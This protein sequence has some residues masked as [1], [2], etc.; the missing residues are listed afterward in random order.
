MI[1]LFIPQTL[2]P[3][4]DLEPSTQQIHYLLHVMRVTEGQ[5]ILVFNG[6]DGEWKV[7]IYNIGKRSCKLK[8]IEQT[9]KQTFE[10]EL[11][12]IFSPLKPKPQEFLIEKATEIGA[13]HLYPVTTERSSTPRFNVEKATQQA[14]EAAEQS[15]R[16]TIPKIFS[17]QPLHSV[18]RNVSS[19][20]PLLVGDET[21]N[22]EPLILSKYNHAR[23]FIIGPEGGWTPKELEYFRSSPNIHTVDLMSNILRAETAGIVGLATLQQMRKYK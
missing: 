23:A 13:T 10:E 7:E 5:S 14:T 12:L 21:H 3:G 19:L 9:R 16:M 15:G 20:A 11:S 4:L 6:Q 1:R 17:L 18:L 22:G 2:A 8:V